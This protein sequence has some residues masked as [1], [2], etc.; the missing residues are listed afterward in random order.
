MTTHLA[1]ASATDLLERYRRG[2]ASPVDAVRACLA[3]IARHG[4]ALGAFALVDEEGALQAA[5]ASEGRWQRG[6]PDG[7]L[8]GI[9]VTIKDLIL[10][11]GW[12]TLRGSKTI[13]PAGPWT[14]DAP[15][16]ARLREAGAIV[17]GKTTTPE[18]GWKAVTDSPL[19]GIARNPWNPALTP[20]GSSGGAGI[21]AA[22]GMGA[23]HVGTDGGGSIRV[24]ASFCGIF[25][26]KPSFGRVP[27]WPL[28][29]TGTVAHLGPMTRTVA[30]AAL[31]MSTISRPD[32][33]DWHSLPYDGRDYLA[34]LD[35]GVEGLRVAWSPRLGRFAVDPE[36][37]ALAASA[38]RVLA[39]AGA[40]VDEV[41]PAMPDV[42]AIFHVHWW[43]GCYN[44]VRGI[45]ADRR[46]LLD[47]GLARIA[48]EAQDLRLDDYLAAIADRAAL[49]A[50]LRAFHERFDLLVTPGVAV[51]P[52]TAG[53]LA[54]ESLG[55]IGSDW[56]RWAS[57]SYPFNLSQQPAASVPCGFTA[58][59][60][61]AG[62]QIVG[63]MHDD[64]RVLR[65][66]RALERARPWHDAYARH[67]APS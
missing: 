40:V 47:P 1:F 21:A 29:P 53:R 2:Q 4:E 35:A 18:M 25:G 58:A 19:R 7:P 41:D 61:P 8:D 55:D 42:H 46:T 6:A 10:T 50:A 22:T 15:V 9:P 65:A 37:A 12:P 67:A 48:R 34:D 30:D 11:R 51:A 17:L 16:V 13:D 63:A 33:R 14:V 64:R 38:V 54:P 26:L 52:F 49:G 27:A 62:L 45:A 43:V 39:D 44:A 24:P 32:A 60:L 28:S 59:G 3:Q 36:V 20:G 56:T 23:L 66:A 57:F 5:R 31:M